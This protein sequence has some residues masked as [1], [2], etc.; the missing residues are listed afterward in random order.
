MTTTGVLR[1]VTEDIIQAMGPAA[2]VLAMG[3]YAGIYRSH[4]NSE[5][6]DSVGNV[7]I[8]VSIILAVQ[9]GGGRLHGGIGVIVLYL[10]LS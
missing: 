6:M 5:Y 9:L 10:A 4:A 7:L 8:G 1:K 3:V 2:T